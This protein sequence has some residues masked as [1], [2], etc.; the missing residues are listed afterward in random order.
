MTPRW[1]KRA[2]RRG[3]RRP[4]TAQRSPKMRPRAPQGAICGPPRGAALIE[5]PSLFEPWG[6]RWPHEASQPRPKTPRHALVGPRW[7]QESPR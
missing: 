5:G 2:P 4:K 3:P 7:P 1:P 6:P